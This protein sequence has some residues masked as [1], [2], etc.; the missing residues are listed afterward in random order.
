[1][2]RV[3][4]AAVVLAGSMLIAIPKS[5]SAASETGYL[6]IIV[7]RGETKEWIHSMPITERPNRPLHFYGNTVRRNY[8]RGNSSARPAETAKAGAAVVTQPKQN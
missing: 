3:S 1:M 8:Y 7:A 6:P 5:A 4:L 2:L